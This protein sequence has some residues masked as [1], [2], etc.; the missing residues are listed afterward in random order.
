MEDLHAATQVVADL[1]W[2][3][4]V[5]T[6]VPAQLVGLAATSERWQSLGWCEHGRGPADALGKGLV[7]GSARVLPWCCCHPRQGSYRGSCGFSRLGSCR[8]SPSFGPHLNSYIH[9]LDEDLHATTEAP[10]K[11]WFQRSWLGWRRWAQGWFTPLASGKLPRQGSCQ[12]CGGPPRQGSC[13][14]SPPLPLSFLCFWSWRC[15]GCLVFW[16][17]SSFPPLPY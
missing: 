11:P 14:G 7:G 2:K 8:G 13:R 12:G 6:Q 4:H 5:A 1:A 17:L 9:D 3:L 16:L 10:P 15:L